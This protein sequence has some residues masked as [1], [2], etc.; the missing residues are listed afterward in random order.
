MLKLRPHHALCLCFFEGKGYSEGFTENTYRVIDR[1]KSNPH[2]EIT[3]GCDVLCE[4]CSNLVEEK[5]SCHEKTDRYDSKTAQLCGFEN[6]LTLT[7]DEFFSTAMERI[8]A[9]GRL[10]DVCGD[11]SWREICLEKSKAYMQKE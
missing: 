3:F 8:I 11:C 5:C 1:L 10:R 4:K 2:I 6:G 9:S 7:A